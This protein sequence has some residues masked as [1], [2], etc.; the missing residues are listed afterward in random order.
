MHASVKVSNPIGEASVILSHPSGLPVASFPSQN[1]EL[2][3]ES[4]REG[5]FSIRSHKQLHVKRKH[6]PSYSSNHLHPGSSTEEN[7][8]K[9]REHS[10]SDSFETQFRDSSNLLHPGSSTEENTSEFMEDS[11]SDSFETEAYTDEEMTKAETEAGDIGPVVIKVNIQHIVS[12]LDWHT[13]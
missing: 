8:S 9:F 10:K 7:T 4:I 5:F 11:E 6:L 13:C 3:S 1:S 12:L 2:C